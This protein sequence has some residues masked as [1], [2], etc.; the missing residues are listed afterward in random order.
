MS[1]KLDKDN[2][3]FKVIDEGEYEV[4]PHKLAKETAKS[5]GNHM[6]QFNYIIRDDVDQPFKG[7]EIRYDNFVETSD[8]LWRVN[9][10]SEAAGLDMDKEYPNGIWEWGDDFLYKAVRV[11][12]GHRKY[13]GK[14]YPEVREFL[15]SMYPGELK[16]ADAKKQE[17]DRK[18][19]YK[20]AEHTEQVEISSDDLPF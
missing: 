9:Q 16:P 2:T 17:A 13:N 5:S 4:Y 18:N 6:A 1:L 7:Q 15:P 3:G 11:R 20:Q 14:T 8:A 12:V 10:A 19:P